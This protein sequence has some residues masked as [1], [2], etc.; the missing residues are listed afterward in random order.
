MVDS[1]LRAVGLQDRLRACHGHE[2]EGGF[3]PNL[4]TPPPAHTMVRSCETR[5][6]AVARS[7]WICIKCSTISAHTVGSSAEVGS[8]CATL[9]FD[10]RKAPVEVTNVPDRDAAGLTA[11]SS[12]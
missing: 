10:D 6:Y 2:A 5:G 11:T 7:D 12:R 3:G 8:S 1:Q 9:F 4:P